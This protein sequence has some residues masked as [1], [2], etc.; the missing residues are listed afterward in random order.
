[1]DFWADGKLNWGIEL[2][3]DAKAPESKAAFEDMLRHLGRLDPTVT[4]ATV[5][6]YRPLQLSDFRVVRFC[7]EALNYKHPKLIQVVINP[8]TPNSVQFITDQTSEAVQLKG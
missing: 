1:M 6:D 2:Q 4:S 5:S 8:A 3:A 7:S